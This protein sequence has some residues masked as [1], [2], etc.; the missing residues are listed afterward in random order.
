MTGFRK[1][2]RNLYEFSY[3]YRPHCRACGKKIRSENIEDH[4][5]KEVR[6]GRARAIRSRGWTQF[7]VAIPRRNGKF[8]RG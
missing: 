7:A 8:V 2:E 3:I 4:G 1:G 5:R 6:R